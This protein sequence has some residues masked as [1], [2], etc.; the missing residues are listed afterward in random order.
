MKKVIILLAFSV[1]MTVLCGCGIIII[2]D[3]YSLDMIPGDIT[4]EY[5]IGNGAMWAEE[6]VDTDV[7]FDKNMFLELFHEYN[8]YDPNEIK[9]NPERCDLKINI[10][11]QPDEWLAIRDSEFNVKAVFGDDERSVSMYRHEEKLYFFVLSLGGAA[12]P[13]KQ[14]KYFMELSEEMSD[15][16]QMIIKSVLG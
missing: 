8:Q 1:L 10:E 2:E 4:C 15:Y 11:Q 6:C 13:D 12:K 9:N 14:G 7:S 16:W 3:N 5:R